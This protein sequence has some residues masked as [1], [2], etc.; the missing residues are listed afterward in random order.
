MPAKEPPAAIRRASSVPTP[1]DELLVWVGY[2]HSSIL[3]WFGPSLSATSCRAPIPASGALIFLC[4]SALFWELEAHAGALD[5]HRLAA[6]SFPYSSD[7]HRC[8]TGE[9]DCKQRADDS[10]QVSADDDGQ[11]R[12]HRMQAHSAAA[13]ARREH[14]VLDHLHHDEKDD[15]V[16]H[17]GERLR[18]ADHHSGQ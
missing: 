2:R 8:N 16:D 3:P 15:H 9:G 12:G 1:A 11:Q 10:T 14:V 4:R 6:P 5:D 13:D 7:Q 18:E 17:E